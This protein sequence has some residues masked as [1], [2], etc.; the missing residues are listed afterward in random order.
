[1]DRWQ[2]FCC[3]LIFIYNSTSGCN[4]DRAQLRENE[5]S[6]SND[7]AAKL[8][9]GTE[10]NS[11]KI[12]KV[13]SEATHF[14]AKVG[15]RFADGSGPYF[16][17]KTSGILGKRSHDGDAN[18]FW[19]NTMDDFL[20]DNWILQKLGQNAKG[21]KVEFHHPFDNAW[22]RGTVVEVFE[23]SSVVSVA[24][25]DGKTK[26]L[27]LGKQGIRLVSPKQDC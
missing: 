12:K 20:D 26:N 11:I 24:L 1:M 22:H 25:D 4:E 6:E 27:E 17:L 8:G 10:S 19:D 2:Y 16:P 9:G 3:F 14:P 21:K 13:S 7:T 23:G 15:G 18:S 5:N